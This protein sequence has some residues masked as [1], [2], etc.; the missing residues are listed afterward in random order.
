MHNIEKIQRLEERHHLMKEQFS[1]ILQNKDRMMK[2]LANSI[3]QLQREKDQI[4]EG[5]RNAL[6][7]LGDE[8]ET[9]S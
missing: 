1:D 5:N 9:Q 2:E 6:C 4:I 8:K 3:R 7:E